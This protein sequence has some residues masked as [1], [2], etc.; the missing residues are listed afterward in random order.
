MTDPLPTPQ[1]PEA[2][3]VVNGSDECRALL[4]KHKIPQAAVDKLKESYKRLY[5]MHDAPIIFKP[6][7]GDQWDRVTQKPDKERARAMRD[8]AS[9]LVVYPA[10]EK[11]A[12][13]LEEF[14]LL[15]ATICDASASIASNK[16]VT[17]AVKL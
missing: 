4:A 14:P 12:D 5:L 11:Y 9:F 6:A 7:S 10:P 8:L 17:E 2:S 16:A 3:P 13:L 15:Y 1:V